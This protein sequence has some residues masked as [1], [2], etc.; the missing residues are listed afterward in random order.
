MRLASREVTEA[1]GRVVAVA[2]EGTQVV[3]VVVMV[4]VVVVVVLVVLVVLVLV[5]MEGTQGEGGVEMDFSKL[6]AH[7]SKTLEME[8]QVWCCCSCC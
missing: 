3:V 4:V 1:A 2:K 6:S 7:Q 8:T 5:V